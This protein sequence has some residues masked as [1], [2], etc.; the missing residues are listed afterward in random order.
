[1]PRL[2]LLLIALPGLLWLSSCSIVNLAYD[3]ASTLVS[4]RLE[5]AFALTEAQ[6]VALEPRLDELL[7]WHRNDELPR[8]RELLESAATQAA[9]GISASEII[10]LSDS[11]RAAWQ[12][13]LARMVDCCSD[14]ATQLTP[15]QIEHFARYHREQSGEYDDYLEMS[16]QQREIFRADRQIGRLQ[17]WFGDFDEG[18][19]LRIRKRLAAV[20]DIWLPWYRFRE[21]RHRELLRVLAQNDD[22]VTMRRELEFV[23][24]EPQSAHASEFERARRLYW[25]GYAAAIEDIDG[26]LSK[27]Q[28][29][30][31]VARLRD[32]AQVVTELAEAD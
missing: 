30:R 5:D 19:E 8:Y 22:P 18:L 25:R 1:M 9:D 26:W 27:Q 32:Y 13:L 12:R 7:A 11:V 6:Q 23:L 21:A 24:F 10:W 17:K 2:P 31:A 3:N 28:R 29:D 4:A 20:P 14:L 15:A 16:E